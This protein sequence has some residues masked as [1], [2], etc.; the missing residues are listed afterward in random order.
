MGGTMGRKQAREGTM[1]LIYQMEINNE[2]SEEALSLYF[3][4]FSLI[5]QKKTI[6]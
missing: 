2:F 4:N 6:S 1:K 3:E 5:Q